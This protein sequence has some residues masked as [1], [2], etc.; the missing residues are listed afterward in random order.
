MKDQRIYPVQISLGEQ[1]QTYSPAFQTETQFSQ[2]W[3]KVLMMAHGKAVVRCQCLGEGEKRL[4]VHSRS[5]SDH[6]HLA[7]FPDTGPE[8]AEDCIFFG[9]DPNAS[10]LGAYKRGVVEE[11]DDGNVKI[12]LKVGLQQRLTKAPDE[13]DVTPNGSATS[14]STR[15]GQSSM[16]LLGLLHY[17]WTQAGLNIWTPA[18]QG[19]RTLGVV[20]HHLM[21]MAMNTYAGRVKL[22]QNLLIGT[23]VAEGS[24][25]KL[26]QAKAHA[27]ADERRRLI[28]IAPLAKYKEGIEN[29]DTV[30]ISGFHG[31][32]YLILSEELRAT[33]L[34]RFSREMNAWIAANPIMAVIQTDPPK[35]SGAHL[36]ADVI[37]MAL[38]G[39]TKDWIPVDSGFESLVAEKLVAENRKFE[40][41]LRFDSDEA[42]FPD[43]WLKD[44]GAP[45]PMEV[46]GMATEAYQT[47]KKEKIA[48]YDQTYGPGNWWSWNGAAG[49]QIPDFPTTT[50]PPERGV[51]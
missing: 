49:D 24:Q 32:P 17:L 33:V 19:K 14:K 29:A 3:K 51:P 26:N 40:K 47:R 1:T 46:W 35:R 30:P 25:P 9:V 41:P 18:M 22:S 16:T 44:R 8:H 20:H 37:D 21:R 36:Q 34:Q 28:V 4:S 23:P 50:L 45:V 27:A 39:M 31:I 6:F 48:H 43:F 38:M 42:V 5:N 7:R 10:G 13:G 11:L 12:K 15:S 2:A